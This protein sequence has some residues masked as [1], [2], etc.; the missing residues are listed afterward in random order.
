MSIALRFAP[1]LLAGS[2]LAADPFA[3][4]WILSLA[5]SKLAGPYA[6]FKSETLVIAEQGD[7]LLIVASVTLRDGSSSTFKEAVAKR[8]GKLG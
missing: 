2:L 3:G 8:G 1:W 4:T 5:E 7:Q 6:G